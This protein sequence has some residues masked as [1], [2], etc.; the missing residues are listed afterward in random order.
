LSTLLQQIVAQQEFKKD[1]KPQSLA[2]LNSSKMLPR[3]EVAE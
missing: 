2:K 1:K 3:D